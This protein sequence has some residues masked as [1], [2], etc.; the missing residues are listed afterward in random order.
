[1]RVPGSRERASANRLTV[2][3]WGNV[4]QNIA[5]DCEAFFANGSVRGIAGRRLQS[6]YAGSFVAKGTARFVDRM[7]TRRS[8]CITDGIEADPYALVT[9]VR[10]GDNRGVRILVLSQYPG[11]SRRMNT[12]GSPVG[13]FAKTTPFYLSTI[14]TLAARPHLPTPARAR[15]KIAMG[16]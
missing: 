12:A 6:N 8:R 5:A 9:D 2:R 4:L 13:A 16:N 7:T 11:S 3:H 14:A 10:P 1:M 15:S